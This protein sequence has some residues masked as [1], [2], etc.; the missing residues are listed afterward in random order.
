MYQLFFLKKT[1][2]NRAYKFLLTISEK[3]INI[4]DSFC[5]IC[6]FERENTSEFKKVFPPVPAIFEL[7]LSASKFCLRRT[8][9]F[10][11]HTSRFR[12]R[13]FL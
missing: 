1:T 10:L 12:S 13:S 9:I 4:S 8:D 6:R 11:S 7:F 5:P 3:K 2:R